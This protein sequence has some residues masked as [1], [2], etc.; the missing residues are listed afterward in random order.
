MPELTYADFTPGRVFELGTV[1]VDEAEMLDFNRRFDPQPFHL[2]PVAAKESLLGSLCASGWYTSAL[3]MR[4][5][6]DGVVGR[7]AAEGSP[8]LTELRW[9][10]PVF[11]G[12]ELTARA[13]VLTVRVSRSR[14]GLGLVGIRGTMSR[15]VQDVMTMESLVMI[16]GA[17]PG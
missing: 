14:P 5:W 4:L 17:P 15:G 13:E 8:G 11:P 6:V 16:G 3:W 9:P 7:C 10:A 12:D 1:T 2:D